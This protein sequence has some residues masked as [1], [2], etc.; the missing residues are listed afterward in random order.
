MDKIFELI[1]LFCCRF[2]ICALKRQHKFLRPVNLR[3][4][5][6]ALLY[7]HRIPGGVQPASSPAENLAV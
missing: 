2:T 3:G 7:N 1:F 5:E 6:T 4:A